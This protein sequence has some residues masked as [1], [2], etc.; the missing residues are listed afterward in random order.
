[1][2]EDINTNN[3]P[4]VEDEKAENTTEELKETAPEVSET[5]VEEVAE[6]LGITATIAEDTT[7]AQENNVID[8][9]EKVT[10][11]EPKSS[12]VS[13]KSGAIG[14]GSADRPAKKSAKK[15]EPKEDT[16]AVHSTRNVTWNGVGKVY[17]GYNI[18]SKTAADKWLTRDHIRSATPEE[19]ARE[20]GK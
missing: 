19:V 8:S 4:V 12:V 9:T 2:S 7:V 15:V 3:E 16:V 14:S 17:R 20:F 5:K 6:E 1:M 18:L 11:E 13:L 10:K